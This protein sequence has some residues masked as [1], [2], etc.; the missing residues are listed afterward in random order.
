MSVA[1][2]AVSVRSLGPEET[3]CGVSAEGA[4]A[5]PNVPVTL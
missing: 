3:M 5:T 1:V 4:P 2:E